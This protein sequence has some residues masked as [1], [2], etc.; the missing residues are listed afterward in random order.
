MMDQRAGNIFNFPEICAINQ[1]IGK[2]LFADNGPLTPS[3]RR[4][5]RNEI[6]EIVCSFILDGN[7]GIMLTPYSDEEHEYTCLTQVDVFLKKPGKAVR[8]AELCHRAMPYPLIVI[9]HDG[10]SMM[11]SMSEKRFSRDGKDQVVL[12]RTDNT[13]WLPTPRLEAFYAEADFSKFRS[14]SFRD[15]YFYYMN[16]LEALTC[17]VITG[18]LQTVGVDPEIR[19]KFLEELHRLDL[20]LVRVK[21]QAKKETGL[22]KLIELNMHAKQIDRRIHE[23]YEKLK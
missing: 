10:D 21:T 13:P 15:L 2:A 23:I 9:L 6:E 19:R 3:D 5:F 12:E 18:K 17:S 4:T 16:L 11:F 1:R 20:E 7:H 14:N 8:V 22:A